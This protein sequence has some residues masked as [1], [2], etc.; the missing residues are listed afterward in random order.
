MA[1]TITL[2]SNNVSVY[3]FDDSETEALIPLK[4]KPDT[5]MIKDGILMD[6]V[7]TTNVM[8]DPSYVEYYI[9]FNTDK[10]ISSADICKGVSKLKAKNVEIGLEVDCDDIETIDFDIYGT[11]VSEIEDCD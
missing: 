5:V 3:V 2:K 6:D 1:Q 11:R 8:V 7:E 4:F 10:N 9:N